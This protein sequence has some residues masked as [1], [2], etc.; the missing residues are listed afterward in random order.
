MTLVKLNL[1][2]SFSIAC[3]GIVKLF[4]CIHCSLELKLKTEKNI[5]EPTKKHLPLTSEPQSLLGK[6][7]L[8]PWWSPYQNWDLYWCSHVWERIKIIKKIL[9]KY[10]NLTWSVQH[11]T[12]NWSFCKNNIS[13]VNLLFDLQNLKL[14]E[15]R[16]QCI[17]FN[18]SPITENSQ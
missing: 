8:W 15:E 11:R 16:S 2:S 13:P 1:R 5:S 4:W 7:S 10:R 3:H 14:P 17:S 18:Y 12:A 9:Q 6:Y